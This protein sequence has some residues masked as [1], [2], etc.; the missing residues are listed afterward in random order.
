V[1]DRPSATE[2]AAMKTAGLLRRLGAMA[3][4]T[5]VVAALLMLAGFAALALTGGEAI[6]AGRL[7][8][9]FLLLLVI[10]GFFCGFWMRGGQTIGMR[11]WR[12][13]LVSDRVP[14]GEVSL[15]QAL[16]RIAA[17]C[18]SALPA[19]LGYLWVLLDR[20]GLAWHDHLSG[21]RVV[22][23]PGKARKP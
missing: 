22:L 23:L 6:A 12:L 9:R 19:G 13:K 2:S 21:T 1:S 15:P 3:Y 18:L 7:W 20:G 5:L 10:A 8:F 11:A 4:D 16:G 14:D 17:A